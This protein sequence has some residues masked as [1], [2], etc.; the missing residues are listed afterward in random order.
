[1]SHGRSMRPGL[2]QETTAPPAAAGWWVGKDRDA[3]SAAAAARA[4][5]LRTSADA[6][7]VKT[8]VNFVE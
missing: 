6:A 4:E 5:Q 8:P 3:F 7:K 1:M 2:R